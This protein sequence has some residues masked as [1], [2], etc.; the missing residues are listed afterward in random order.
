MDSYNISSFVSDFIHLAKGIWSSSMLW[1]VSK[2]VPLYDNYMS[3]KL[4]GKFVPFYWWMIFYYI[5]IPQFISS[6]FWWKSGFFQLWAIRNDAMII[7]VYV[8]VWTCV[9]ISLGQITRSGISGFGD[10]YI[11]NFL[12][13]CRTVFQRA[14]KFTLPLAIHAG[15]NSTTSH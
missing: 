3:I 13:N 5:D 14:V 8:F 11:F 15:S 1:H 12:G 10:K 2:F 4:G 7:C 9:S 6:P